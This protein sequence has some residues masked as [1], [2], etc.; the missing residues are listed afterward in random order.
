[1]QSTKGVWYVMSCQNESAESRQARRDYDEAERKKYNI[2]TAINKIKDVRNGSGAAATGGLILLGAI[3]V[4]SGPVGWAGAFA[5]ALIIGGGGGLV[6]SQKSLDELRSDCVKARDEMY[7][8]YQRAMG[9]CEDPNCIPPR[10]WTG[11][12][13]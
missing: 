8:A 4:I 2:E 5:G 6:V 1:M 11:G 9:A 7:D 10:T 3:V 13:N 12:C